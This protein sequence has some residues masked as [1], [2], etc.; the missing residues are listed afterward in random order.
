MIFMNSNTSAFI[1]IARNPFKFRIFLLRKLPNAYFAGLRVKELDE[2]HAIVTI[3]YKWFTKNP[4]RSTYF[5]CL[6]M[7]AELSTGLLAMAHLYKHQPTVSMLVLRVESDFLKK[8]TGITSFHCQDG[9]MMQQAIKETLQSGEPRTVN[10]RSI[11]VNDAGDTVA[12]FTVQWSFKA[13]IKT[14]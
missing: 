6:G 3:P 1:R 2:Q 12:S 11:G 9:L 5:A 10:A 13:K 8:A 7:A 14:S 4:F